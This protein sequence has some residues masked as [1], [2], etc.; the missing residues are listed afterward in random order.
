MGDYPWLDPV[1]ERL[2]TIAD[3]NATIE[4]QLILGKGAVYVTEAPRELT[5]VSVVVLLGQIGMNGVGP[6]GLYKGARMSLLAYTRFSDMAR[7][8]D[9]VIHGAPE[10]DRYVL[11]SPDPEEPL[12]GVTPDTAVRDRI[13]SGAL[14]H[15][16]FDGQRAGTAVRRYVAAQPPVQR[17]PP[18]PKPD[19]E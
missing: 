19:S 2:Y 14:L 18:W 11:A 4:A 16:A 6:L 12:N 8:A 7:L 9:V 1:Q 3:L 13:V 17:D 15:A 10:P 5:H